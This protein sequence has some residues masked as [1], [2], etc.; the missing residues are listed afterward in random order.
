M[1][2]Y[3]S[4]EKIAEFVKETLE[5]PENVIKMLQKYGRHAL[6]RIDHCQLHLDFDNRENSPWN[7]DIINLFPTD[8]PVE[9]TSWKG[10]VY[11]HYLDEEPVDCN[12]KGTREIMEMIVTKCGDEAKI[13]EKIK[14]KI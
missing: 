7:H 5:S 9:M 10:L 14:V 12:C 2:Q 3:L 6:F 8:H 13:R 1:I 4:K 11:V